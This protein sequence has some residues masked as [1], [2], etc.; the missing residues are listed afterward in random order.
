MS[1][2]SALSLTCFGRTLIEKRSGAGITLTELSA[3][4]QVPVSFLEELERG[5]SITPG[6]DLCYRLAQAINTRSRQGFLVQDLWQAAC[7]DRVSVMVRE[8][9]QQLRGQHT[10]AE[11]LADAQPRKTRAA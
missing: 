11:Q 2:R 7:L 1:A 10:Q 4:I 9:D 5:T 8:A 6:F 3:Q